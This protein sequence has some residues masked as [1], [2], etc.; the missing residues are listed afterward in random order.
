MARQVPPGRT[1]IATVSSGISASD[2]PNQSAN[3]SG[4]VHSRQTRAR[5]ADV[6][7]RV[8]RAVHDGGDIGDG[9]VDSGAGGQVTHVVLAALTSAEDA[10]V[11]ARLA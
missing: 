11:H 1:S 6:S 4:S 8:T 3:A 5:G 9:G 2:P 10:D 7:F